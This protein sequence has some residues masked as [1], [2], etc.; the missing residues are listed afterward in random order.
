MVSDKTCDVGG[1]DPAVLQ[2]TERREIYARLACAWPELVLSAI[3]A[4]GR[5]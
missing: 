1:R 3:A 2:E 4:S 5:A